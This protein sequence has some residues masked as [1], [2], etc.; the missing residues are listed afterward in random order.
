[1]IW[2]MKGR[3]EH[4][5][6]VV[7]GWKGSRCSGRE[8]VTVR[9]IFDNCLISNDLFLVDMMYILVLDNRKHTFFSHI[10]LQVI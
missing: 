3:G 1:M 9:Y 8:G 7:A 5:G 4:E 6:V 2:S 10:F